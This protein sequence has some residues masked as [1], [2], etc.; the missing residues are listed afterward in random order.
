MSLLGTA[1]GQ[2]IANVLY[3]GDE[4]GSPFPWDAIV[5]GALFNEWLETHLDAWLDAH[6]TGYSLTTL[7]GRAVNERGVV[8]SDNAVELAVNQPGTIVQSIN[9]PFQTAIIR[10]PTVRN[11]AEGA[12]G[13]KRSYLAVGP[14]INNALTE[15][16][17]LTLGTLAYMQAV[18]DAVSAPIDSG[19]YLHA[20]VRIG[21]TVAPAQPA[22]G[23]VIDGIVDPFGSFRKSRKRRANGT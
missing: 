9:G 2:A 13:M 12:R 3:Y 15:T 21:R 11:E 14:L 18:A 22:I 19:L 17:E 20:P 16:G 5:I 8:I 23:L 10:L 4:N 1:G 7:V 6:H